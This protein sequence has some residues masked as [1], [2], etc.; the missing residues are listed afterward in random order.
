MTSASMPELK[1]ACGAKKEA[2]FVSLAVVN[3][4]INHFSP[5]V[6]IVSRYPFTEIRNSYVPVY[7]ALSLVRFAI[8]T[9]HA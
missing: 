4:G 7:M 9:S 8:S 6:I 3:Q 1:Q 2:E 5:S